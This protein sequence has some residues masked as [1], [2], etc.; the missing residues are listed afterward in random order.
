M[1]LTKKHNEIYTM[2][3]EKNTTK[4][5]YTIYIIIIIINEKILILLKILKIKNQQHAFFN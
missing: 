1:Y 2:Y 3:A 5:I 4:Q